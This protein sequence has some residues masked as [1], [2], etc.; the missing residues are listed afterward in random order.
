MIRYLH[1]C[2]STQEW[3]KKE[4]KEGVYVCGSQI[5]GKGKEGRPWYS[6][7]GLGLYMTVL[8]KTSLPL[9]ELLELPVLIAEKIKEWLLKYEIEAEIKE[10]NDVLVGGKKISGIL[11]EKKREDLFIGIGVNLNH[12]REDFP[13]YL[14]DKATS[15]FIEKGIILNPLR[16][17]AEI[18]NF[19]EDIKL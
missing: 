19:M 15:V 5:R 12:K 13:L 8:R 3:A 2:I 7:P 18:M 11:M 17:A 4:R 9:D 14:K 1:R 16:C 10:P 6:P